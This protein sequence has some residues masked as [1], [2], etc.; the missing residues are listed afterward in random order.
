MDVRMRARPGVLLVLALVGAPL[1]APS[2]AFADGKAAVPATS[3]ASKI[4]RDA[5]NVTG[6][7][8]FMEICVQANAKYV[9]K[10]IT[11]AIELYQK[12]IKLQPRNPLG[13]YFLGEAF[14]NQGSLQEAATSFLEAD[15]VVDNG[16]GWVKAKVLFV[17]ADMREREKK[18]DDAKVA[19][20]RYVEFASKHSEL[21]VFPSSGT[22]R[23]QAIDE[24]LKQD[25]AYDI[26]RQRIKE[27]KTSGA[28][29]NN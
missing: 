21:G 7:S 22:S 27:E 5:N 19:W 15:Q 18:W 17:L 14:L 1:M 12:A 11:G 4:R 3:G 10:D 20:Q 23:I 24:M 6:I 16:P 25:K 8:E 9:S 29:Q 26:V 2:V 13:H 28:G